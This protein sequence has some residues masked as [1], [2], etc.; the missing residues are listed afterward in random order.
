MRG[1]LLHINQFIQSHLLYYHVNLT[2]LFQ[3]QM[4]TLLA[5][6]RIVELFKIRVFLFLV[7][8]EALQVNVIFNHAYFKRVHLQYHLKILFKYQE[9]DMLKLSLLQQ[10]HLLDFMP[11]NFF[12]IV[13]LQ[14][15]IQHIIIFTQ[16]LLL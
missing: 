10:Q 9:L 3:Y 4:N 7:I 8:L 11:L 16:L 13:Q 2:G 5:L 14:D 1:I 12:S 6:I 15:I